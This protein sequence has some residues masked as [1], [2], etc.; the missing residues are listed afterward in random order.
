M[1]ST[2]FDAICW[3][4][5]GTVVDTERLW[6]AQEIELIRDL[7]GEP[8]HEFWKQSVGTTLEHSCALFQQWSGTDLSVEEIG[9]ELHRRVTEAFATAEIPW[10]PGVRELL[11]GAKKAGVPQALVTATAR[12][13]LTAMLSRMDTPFD[14]VVAGDDVSVGKPDPEGYLTACR[15]LGVAPERA[16]VIED[17]VA[18]AAAGNAAGCVVLAVPSMVTPPPAPR[19]VPLDSLAGLTLADLSR[20]YEQ[21]SRA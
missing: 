9:R 15:A 5:D 13:V 1:T 14:V 11:A 8:P 2:T 6:V 3:D 20:L 16:L 21:G 17:S 19:R 7:G 10:N 18:G 12:K 4:F